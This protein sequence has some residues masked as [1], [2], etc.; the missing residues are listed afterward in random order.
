MKKLPVRKPI[1][2]NSSS[3]TLIKNEKYQLTYFRFNN[4][5]SKYNALPLKISFK[6]ALESFASVRGHLRT[7]LI[8][9][10]AHTFSFKISIF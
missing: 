1:S 10:I 6:G 7:A 3:I 9:C 4:H 5:A 8:F 2:R